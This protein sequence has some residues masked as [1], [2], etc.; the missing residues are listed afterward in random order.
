MYPGLV[1]LLKMLYP[2][3]FSK[4]YQLS[5]KL[6]LFILVFVILVAQHASHAFY[7]SVRLFRLSAVGRA[8]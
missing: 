8:L 6:A 3:P 1:L 5:P 7:L 4:L 2:P